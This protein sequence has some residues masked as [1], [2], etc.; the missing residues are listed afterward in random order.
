MEAAA[1]A[2]G[3]GARP[4]QTLRAHRG[5]VTCCDAA[6]TRFVTG[7]G[8]G[9]LVAWRWQAGDGWTRAGDAPR[10]HRYG[11]TAARWA[12]GGCLLAS[13][14]VDGAARVWDGRELAPRVLLA[15]PAAPALRALCWAGA[16]R[17]LCGY[18]DGA[19]LVWL[20]RDASLLARVGAHQGALHAL[21]A[22][23]RGALLLAACTE[24]VLKVFDLQGE[25]V[26]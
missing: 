3:S 11:V 1:E 10:A 23:A 14:G 20:V 16:A 17:L 6:G 8:E 7:G 24:G 18:D 2:L 13:G 19:V 26:P 9:T 12:P 15:A 22:P 4:L 25:C 21:A 5:E